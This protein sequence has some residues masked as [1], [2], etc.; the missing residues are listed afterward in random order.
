MIIENITYIK[1]L[2]SYGK[3]NAALTILKPNDMTFQDGETEYTDDYGNLLHKLCCSWRSVFSIDTKIIIGCTIKYDVG[4]T[5]AG[6]FDL[7]ELMR[8]KIVTVNV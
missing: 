4:K 1:F 8:G 2:K 3:A 6:N 7:E 5:I